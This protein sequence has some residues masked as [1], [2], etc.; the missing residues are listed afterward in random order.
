MPQFCAPLSSLVLPQATSCFRGLRGL[1]T[2]RVIESDRVRKVEKVWG[3]LSLSPNS[4]TGSLFSLPWCVSQGFITETKYLTQSYF[5]REA[6][7]G[8]R[9]QK[10]LCM[11]RVLI[12]SGL[13]QGGALCEKPLSGNNLLITLN[14]TSQR[15]HY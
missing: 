5:K 2:K 14:P 3:E 7:F 8:F 15:F 12:A 6:Y 10:F 9:F 1:G 11:V 13:W 4:I